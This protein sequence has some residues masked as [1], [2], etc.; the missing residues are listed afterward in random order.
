MQLWLP[1]EAWDRK[2]ILDFIHALTSCP[3]AS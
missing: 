3:L 2:A 1:D